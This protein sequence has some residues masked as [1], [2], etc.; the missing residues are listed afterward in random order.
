MN[1]P[2]NDPLSRMSL[3]RRRLLA[4][5]GMMGAAGMSLPAILA[6]CGG[7]SDGASSSSSDTSASGSEAPLGGGGN[8]LFFENWPEYIDPTEDDLIGTV[9]RFM[10]ASGVEMN[11]AETYNDNVEYFAKIQPLLGTGKPIDPDI[12]A[13]TSWLVG[14]LI[15]LGWVDKL[16]IDL[17]PNAANLRA[18][19][20]KPAWDPTGEY[21]LPWQTGF[22]GIA[23]NIESTGRELK[24][25]EDL[26][27]PAFSGKI[28]M[29]TEMRDT[30][31][32]LMLADGVDISTVSTFDAAANAFDRL[33]AAKN[34][35]QIRRFTGNDYL[36]D[37]LS[38]P[39]TTGEQTACFDHNFPP[40]SM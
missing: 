30:M 10:A 11:Y 27:D 15:S 40:C 26:F 2:N 9:E 1:T 16:P 20:Q 5:A 25:T 37:L 7:S 13:P 3:S 22:A 8:S 17:V 39:V 31:G 19:L 35:G 36:N 38:I 28:G 21:S 29:L 23:Y 33:E 12:I 6:A 24:S 34:D 18:D 4:R 14:R 32:L